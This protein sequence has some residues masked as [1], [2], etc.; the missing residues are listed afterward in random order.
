[1]ACKIGERKQDGCCP[2]TTPEGPHSHLQ[3]M[4]E[5]K[6][7]GGGHPRE[8]RSCPSHLAVS[9]WRPLLTELIL[10]RLTRGELLQGW[11]LV[12]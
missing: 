1:M 6:E 4:Q 3:L 8:K 12:P 11:L 5:R 7:E 10:Q 9:L 2:S